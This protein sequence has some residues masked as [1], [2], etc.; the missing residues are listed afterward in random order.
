VLSLQ[1]REDIHLPV[2]DQLIV[3]LYSK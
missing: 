1:K 2:N 3:E